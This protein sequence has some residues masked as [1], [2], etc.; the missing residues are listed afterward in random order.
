MPE[1]HWPCVS[2]SHG[3]NGR[4]NWPVNPPPATT[5]ACQASQGTSSG[6][7]LR[8]LCV[9]LLRLL[10]VALPINLQCVEGTGVGEQ[11]LLFFS[12]TV[13]PIPFER[14]H[15][16]AFVLPRLH[17]PLSKLLSPNPLVGQRIHR[18][19]HPPVAHPGL[20]AAWELSADASFKPPGLE[21][22]L[23]MRD[24]SISSFQ[25][26]LLTEGRSLRA[27]CATS[28]T[29]DREKLNLKLES[30]SV[31]S[32]STVLEAASRGLQGGAS[33]E[34]G[35]GESACLGQ[36]RAILDGPPVCSS[37]QGQ[38]GPRVFGCAMRDAP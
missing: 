36:R 38:T 37:V 15:L 6:P 5:R 8:W 10:E 33:V 14:I 23:R 11:F 12:G 4:A 24:G 25:G 3:S 29:L 28:G 21:V 7:T 1:L 31:T 26:M 17:A 18:D 16:P 32:D 13:G 2:V 19:A 35:L 34:V 30:F 9:L 27:R 20:L 22:L